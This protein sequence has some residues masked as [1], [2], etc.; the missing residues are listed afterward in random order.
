MM[1]VKRLLMGVGGIAVLAALLQLAAPKAVHAL[2][3]TLVQV[4]NTA[5]TPA[6]TQS[7]PT[8]ASQI[9]TLEASISADTFTKS[10]GFYQISPQGALSS[11]LFQTPSTTQS[12]VITSIEFSP[13][14]GSGTL[15]LVFVD[16]YTLNIYEQW[17]IPAGSVTNL[18]Y[19]SGLVLGP[20]VAPIIASQGGSTSAAMNVYLHGYMT[21]N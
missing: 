9:V 6:I 12:F 17:K 7:V 5:A 2:V 4:T 13:T 15:D 8:L 10:N 21:S 16:G 3:A 20:N 19:P 14:A 1:I 18:E 11:T